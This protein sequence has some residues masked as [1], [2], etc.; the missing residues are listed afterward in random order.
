MLLAWH[1]QAWNDYL[2]WTGQDKKI[3]RKINGLLKEI[4]RSPYAGLGKP[5]ALS[6]N[7]SGWWSRR[8]DECNRLVYKIDG[9]T[10]I[11]AHCKGHY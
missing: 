7:Y 9:D 2:A 11:I 4:M 8:I 5:E 1:P 3:T 10:C 6:A